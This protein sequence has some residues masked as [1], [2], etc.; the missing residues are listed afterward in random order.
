MFNTYGAAGDA[1]L[2]RRLVVMRRNPH[3]GGV[4]VSTAE[5]LAAAEFARFESDM[6]EDDDSESDYSDED[7][8]DDDSRIASRVR[9]RRSAT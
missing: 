9:C 4:E 3:G 1:E 6:H 2:L 8:E 7:D 5:C